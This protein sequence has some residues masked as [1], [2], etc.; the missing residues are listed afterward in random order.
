MD[1]ETDSP[2]A[3]QAKCV[4]SALM[5][6]DCKFFTH[7]ETTCYLLRSC[8]SVA[9]VPGCVS[10]PYLPDYDS[11]GFSTTSGPEETTTGIETTTPPEPTTTAE[12][13]PAPTTS[14][15]GCSNFYPGFLCNAELNLID[16]ITHI[17]TP[18][19]CQ[20]LCQLREGCNFWSHW[21]EVRDQ[22]IGHCDLHWSCPYLEED[23]CLSEADPK[24]PI[25]PSS[26]YGD[27][28]EDVNDA[29][30][31]LDAALEKDMPPG[32]GSGECGCISGP[33]Y[34]NIG[35]CDFW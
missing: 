10:G 13:T 26:I 5:G 4:N 1:Q 31:E 25:V 3:C 27:A 19:E 9:P 32:P 22:H 6:G 34:P 24:C 11:C 35:E 30:E 7:F 21:I 12:Q 16:T 2:G 18:T 15:S 33:A 20:T 29:R 17:V 23:K 14:E 8:D 28:D